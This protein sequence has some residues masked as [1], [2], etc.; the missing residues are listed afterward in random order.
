[1]LSLSLSSA[2]GENISRW[3]FSLAH[4]LFTSEA[5]EGW[6]WFNSQFPSRE[7]GGQGD[8]RDLRLDRN[9]GGFV[10]LDLTVFRYF[11]HFDFFE[12][13]KKRKEKIV[14]EDEI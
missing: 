14:E 4:C 2:T 11:P 1:M 6:F 10:N 12:K 3:Q 13:E 9:F 7:G 8:V 5:R